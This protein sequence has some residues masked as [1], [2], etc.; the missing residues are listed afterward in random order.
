MKTYYKIN[1]SIIALLL[2]CS[3]KNNSDENK[4]SSQESNE[5]QL[6]NTKKDTTINSENFQIFWNEF[7]H[8]IN[9]TNSASLVEIFQIPFIINGYEDSDPQL[10]LSDSDSINKIFKD[11]LKEEMLSYDSISTHLQLINSLNNLEDFP[12][13]SAYENNRRIEN[14]EFVKNEIGWRL[15]RIYM[16]TKEM[17]QRK[18]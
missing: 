1:F 3:C 8:L 6:E 13:Y 10:K 7:R 4:I 18:R 2:L 11:F 9:D 16:N 12:G 17:K 5:V 14:M 15:S